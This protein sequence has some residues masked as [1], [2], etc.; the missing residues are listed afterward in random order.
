M[1]ISVEDRVIG[2]STLWKEAEYNFA[3]WDELV[4]LDWDIAYQEFLPRIIATDNP[5]LYYEELQK[6]ISLLKDGH[7]YVVMP[8]ELCISYKIPIE[9]SYMNGKHLLTMVPKYSDVKLFSEIIAINEIPIYT[10]LEEYVFPYTW[11]ENLTSAFFQNKLANVINDREQGEIYIETNTGKFSFEKGVDVEIIDIPELT[12]PEFKKMQ[13]LFE[14]VT[15]SIY[16]TE[17]ELIYIDIPTFTREELKEEI[18]RNSNLFRECKGIIIDVRANGGGSSRNSDAVAQL[19]FQGSFKTG[20][21]KSPVHIA[22]FKA[23]GRYQDLDEL[24]LNHEWEKKIYD[25][26]KHQLFDVDDSESRVEECPIFLNQPVVILAGTKTASAAESFLAAMKYQ[27]RATI[28]GGFSYGSN[29]QPYMGILPGGGWYGICTHKCYLNN[30]VN[31]HNTGIEPDILVEK[32]IEQWNDGF[33]YILDR[34]LQ[35]IRALSESKY[36]NILYK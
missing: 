27:Q 14:S 18:Y 6:F 21:T 24:N 35:E 20:Y 3:Y 16:K 5:R 1:I 7:T 28:V 30:G 15:H 19:F 34:G 13:K 25:V 8:E 9:T 23:Y 29:G 4:D 32:S 36:S 22:A 17:D 12:H 26:C 31:Y 10:Y 2:L 33:D 11:H